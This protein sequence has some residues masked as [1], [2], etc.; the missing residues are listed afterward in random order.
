M[1]FFKVFDQVPLPFVGGSADHTDKRSLFRVGDC[2]LLEFSR[3]LCN[4][5]THAAFQVLGFTGSRGR[6]FRHSNGTNGIERHF[7]EVIC[8]LQS[9]GDLLDSLLVL[10]DFFC[11]VFSKVFVQI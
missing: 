10:M 9:M 7:Q 6:G 11:V 3:P 2:M 8:L 4:K 5:G 1:A